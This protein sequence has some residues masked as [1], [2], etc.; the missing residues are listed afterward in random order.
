VI[1]GA[2]FDT[3][4]E[5]RRFAEKESFGYRLLSDVRRTAGRAYEVAPKG[6][7]GSARRIAYLIDPEGLIQRAY[8]VSD[9][10][11]FAAAVLSDLATIGGAG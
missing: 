8:K 9:T 10:A 7:A 11:G 2:S 6:D 4:E 5:N 3:V 1:L